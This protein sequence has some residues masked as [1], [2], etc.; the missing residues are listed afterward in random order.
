MYLLSK[1]DVSGSGIIIKVRMAQNCTNKGVQKIGFIAAL[2]H[3]TIKKAL[4][5]KRQHCYLNFALRLRDPNFP[6]LSCAQVLFLSSIHHDR[7]F[8]HFFKLGTQPRKKKATY[9]Q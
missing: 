9:E 2:K 4:L 1:D 3:L 5:L 6:L 7:F 8:V